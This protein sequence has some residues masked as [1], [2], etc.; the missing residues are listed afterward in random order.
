M[1]TETITCDGCGYDLATTANCEDYRLCLAN[2]RIP[3]A[4]GVVTMMAISPAI[5]RA[6]HFCGVRCLRTWL[7]ENY[8]SA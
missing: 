6:A 3:S 4:G 1:R 7:G 8:P 2:E 5:K